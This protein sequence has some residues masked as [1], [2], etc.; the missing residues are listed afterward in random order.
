MCSHNLKLMPAAGYCTNYGLLK[1]RRKCKTNASD[2]G[3][4]AQRG[5]HD[6]VDCTCCDAQRR[7]MQL[8]QT[9][10]TLPTR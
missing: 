10:I 5:S 7:W 4:V 8:E 2:A 6:S 3:I 9:A 1:I